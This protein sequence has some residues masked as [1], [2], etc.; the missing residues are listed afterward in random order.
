MVGFLEWKSSFARTVHSVYT[1]H[2]Q[3]MN[4]GARQLCTLVIRR[5]TLADKDQQ[6]KHTQGKK[7]PH[8]YAVQN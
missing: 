5:S 4:S 2:N 1:V 3:K 7:N 8:N 6:Q